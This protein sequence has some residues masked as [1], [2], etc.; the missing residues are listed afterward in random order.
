MAKKKTSKKKTQQRNMEGEL[1]IDLPFTD[2]DKFPTDHF[3]TIALGHPITKLYEWSPSYVSESNYNRR[4][5]SPTEDQRKA[6][7]AYDL[8]CK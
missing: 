4:Q 7:V 3:I 1:A 5:S 6:G 2:L 8:L